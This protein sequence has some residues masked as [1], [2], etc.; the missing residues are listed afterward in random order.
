MKRDRLAISAAVADLG[1][2]WAAAAITGTAPLAAGGPLPAY[3]E[4]GRCADLDRC[5]VQVVSVREP[6]L[7]TG[8]CRLS[9]GAPS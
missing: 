3:F 4:L 1:L 9:R 2:S 6:W 7:D 5:G 8:I